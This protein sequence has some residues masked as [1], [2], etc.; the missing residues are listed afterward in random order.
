M[1]AG[2]V[3]GEVL[4]TFDTTIPADFTARLTTILTD[5]AAAAESSTVLPGAF[6]FFSFLPDMRWMERTGVAF[7]RSLAT[8]RQLQ[9]HAQIR[10]GDRLAGRSVITEVTQDR[11]GRPRC[12]VTIGTEYHR[13]GALVLEESVTY[14]NLEGEQP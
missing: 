2:P 1:T 7:E 12:S 5:D 14:L 11:H 9:V 13:E 8:R 3:V 6:V 4:G 10:P